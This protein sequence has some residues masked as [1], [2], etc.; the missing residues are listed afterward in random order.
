MRRDSGQMEDLQLPK[1]FRIICWCFQG[2]DLIR[3]LLKK[4]KAFARECD[5]VCSSGLEAK[6][7]PSSHVGSWSPA[8]GRNHVESTVVCVDYECD[9]GRVK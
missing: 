8:P 5:I 1:Y 4:C 3:T 6:F 2:F 9:E 7:S